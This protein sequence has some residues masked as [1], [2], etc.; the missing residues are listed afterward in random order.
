LLT[1]SLEPQGQGTLVTLRHTGV[2]DDEFGRQHGE[3]WAF[4]LSAME[5]RFA[6]RGR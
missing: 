6:K 1:V 5:Q 4:V 3:G 2:P